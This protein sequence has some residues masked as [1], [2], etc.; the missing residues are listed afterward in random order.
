MPLGL[1]G[2]SRHGC[3]KRYRC[4]DLNYAQSLPLMNFLPMQ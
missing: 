4:L 2:F 3:D 1:E